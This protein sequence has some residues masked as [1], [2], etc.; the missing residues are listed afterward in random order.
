MKPEITDE[1]MNKCLVGS[2]P[3][4]GILRK[5]Q[6]TDAQ[7]LKLC[8]LSVDSENVANLCESTIPLSEHHIN[9][10][11]ENSKPVSIPHIFLLIGSLTPKQ[12]M[13]GLNSDAYNVRIA[14][15]QHKCCT[16]EQKVFYHLK[17]GK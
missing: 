14:A 2:C 16:D 13:L 15:Y 10:L 6:L 4:V 8:V 11:L 12:I 5:F 3:D 1:D 17:W 7:I 9:Y